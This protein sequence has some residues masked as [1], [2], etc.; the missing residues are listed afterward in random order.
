VPFPNTFKK[1]EK[2]K[3][4][5]KKRIQDIV[6]FLVS[7]AYDYKQDDLLLSET[8]PK[9]FLTLKTELK[10]ENN[11]VLKWYDE[12]IKGS[13][14]KQY[15]EMLLKD[16]YTK[17]SNWYREQ[18]GT[19]RVKPALN[20]FSK[21]NYLMGT[22]FRKDFIIDRIHQGRSIFLNTKYKDS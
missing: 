9:D 11:P 13:E 2:I 3:T 15:D 18:Y 19:D 20:H 5:F 22:D 10:H 6:S 1:N 7:L 4:E 21:E 8:L 14:L 12:E 16:F 17:Y